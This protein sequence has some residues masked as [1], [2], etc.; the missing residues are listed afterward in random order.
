MNETCET[1][2]RGELK[3]EYTFGMS[4]ATVETYTCGHAACLNDWGE[5]TWHND[6]QSA[7]GQARMLAHKGRCDDRVFMGAK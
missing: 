4:D 2:G 7:A 3:K 1:C 6:Y 5:A